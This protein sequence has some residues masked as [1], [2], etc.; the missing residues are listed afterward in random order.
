MD[1]ISSSWA[2]LHQDLDQKQQMKMFGASVALSTD[3]T[4]HA[5][6]APSN[7]DKMAS[8]LRFSLSMLMRTTN[9]PAAVATGM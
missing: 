5:V 7:E 6:G 4:I 1:E 3:D 8:T 2:Q 9:P